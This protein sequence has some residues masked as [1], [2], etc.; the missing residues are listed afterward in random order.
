MPTFEEFAD[1]VLSFHGRPSRGEVLVPVF[2]PDGARQDALYDRAMEYLKGLSFNLFDLRG[3]E[4]GEAIDSFDLDWP[5]II[6]TSPSSERGSAV[7]DSEKNL[8]IAAGP[9]SHPR[10]WK[11]LCD[12]GVLYT[13]HTIPPAKTSS[14]CI[15]VPQEACVAAIIKARDFSRF[16]IQYFGALGRFGEE[17]FPASP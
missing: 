9:D 12:D 13:G 1:E 8:L 15:V 7:A 10:F 3:R 6:E 11:F 4:Y 16:P 17:E 2:I 5:S 14:R